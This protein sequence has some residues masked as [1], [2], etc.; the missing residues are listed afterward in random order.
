LIFSLF[1]EET[2]VHE[3]IKNE[4]Q[5][6]CRRCGTCCLKGGP[7]LHTGDLDL[8]RGGQLPISRLI[9]IRKG[10][11][12][13]HP[14]TGR[15]QAVDC[16]LVKICGTGGDW[17]CFYFSTSRGCTIYALRPIACRVLKCWDPTDISALVGKDTLTRL[18]I[19]AEGDPLRPLVVEYE[20]LCPCPDMELIRRFLS[21]GSLEGPLDNLQRL[22]DADLSFRGRVVKAHDISLAEEV[23]YFGRPIFQLLQMLG[24]E[25]DEIAKGIR[26]SQS[27]KW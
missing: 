22:V 21:S 23:F 1:D 19:L 12:V 18:D 9:T 8:V 17:R 11:L 7:A 25:I 10:E 14:L 24:V 16:E 2:V 3:K 13:S 26:L 5:T 6:E 4:I 27:H 20:R 15:V